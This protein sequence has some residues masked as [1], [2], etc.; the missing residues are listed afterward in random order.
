MA[1]IVIVRGFRWNSCLYRFFCLL[2]LR[3]SLGGVVAIWAE[4]RVRRATGLV[5][6]NACEGNPGGFRSLYVQVGDS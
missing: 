3:E 1:I 2:N 6:I 5:T 4:M